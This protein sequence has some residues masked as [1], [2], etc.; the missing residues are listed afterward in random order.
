ML[1]ITK[2]GKTQG[3]GHGS[4][5][6]NLTWFEFIEG[7]PSRSGSHDKRGEEYRR[8]RGSGAGVN[9]LVE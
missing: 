8:G 6:L 3:Q 9:E 5:T 7:W 2:A 1:P 4:F